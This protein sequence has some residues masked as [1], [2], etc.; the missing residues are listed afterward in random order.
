MIDCLCPLSLSLL[1]CCRVEHRGELSAAAWRAND[2]RLYIYISIDTREIRLASIHEPL[3]L[4]LYPHL[5]TYL[6]SHCIFSQYLYQFLHHANSRVRRVKSAEISELQKSNWTKVAHYFKRKIKRTFRSFTRETI[7]LCV[8]LSF[9]LSLFHVYFIGLF[10]IRSLWRRV[11]S[12]VESDTSSR[13][14]LSFAP[15]FFTI[16]RLSWKRTCL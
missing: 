7:S 1:P 9:S 13:S 3:I 2:T 12:R 6:H 16:L 11:E 10:E 5:H 15:C 8:H 4:Q 14:F